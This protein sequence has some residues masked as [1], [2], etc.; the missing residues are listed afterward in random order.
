MKNQLLALLKQSM[1]LLVASL[2]GD[3]LP[4]LLEP[5]APV[6]SP[7]SSPGLR[8]DPTEAAPTLS[9]EAEKVLAELTVRSAHEYMDESIIAFISVALDDRDQAFA[10]LEKGYQSRAGNLPWMKVEPKFDPLRSDPRFND[11]LR[12]MGL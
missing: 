6:P 9:N 3:D 5:P 2:D 12:R 11:L 7:G 8:V 10:W 1:P 4:Y